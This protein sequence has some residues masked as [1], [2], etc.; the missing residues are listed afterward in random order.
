M[1]DGPP[2]I[3]G[4]IIGS[5]FVDASTGVERSVLERVD[6]TFGNRNFDVTLIGP[7]VTVP[8]ADAQ[9][10]SIAWTSS[11]LADADF[12][13]VASTISMPGAVVTWTAY[14]PASTTSLTY[15]EL[16]APLAAIAAGPTASWTDPVLEIVSLS[17]F[18]Y[19]SALPI[20]D[21]DLYWWHDLGAYLPTG[22]VAISTAR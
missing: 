3:E 18:T 17:D 4:S 14:G 15:P 20:L 2:L 8:I 5:V 7:E 6:Q 22:T 1:L 11:D 9:A 12:V 13:A 19:A 16:P 21:R 10:Q